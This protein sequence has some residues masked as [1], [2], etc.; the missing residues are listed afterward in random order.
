MGALED[1]DLNTRASKE[2]PLDNGVLLFRKAAE[3]LPFGVADVEEAR[4]RA[5]VRGWV[6]PL[7]GCADSLADILSQL[8]LEGTAATMDF[9]ELVALNGVDQ[10][11]AAVLA[12][13]TE[14]NL[15]GG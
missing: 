7:C 15:G 6:T 13:A 2:E 1:L 14:L 8:G 12:V 5:R 11:V 4:I 9:C 10:V 3:R